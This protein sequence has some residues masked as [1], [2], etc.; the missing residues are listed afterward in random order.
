MAAVLYDPITRKMILLTA[1]VLLDLLLG[2]PHGLWHPVQ[3]IGALAARLERVLRRMFPATC[4][5]QMAAGGC[6]VVCVLCGVAI[7]V[8]GVTVFLYHVHFF[9]GFLAEL[10]WYYSALAARSLHRESR[11]VRLALERDGLSAGRT[12]VSMI[13]GR[14]TKT[15]DE[16]G[17]I[18]AAVETVA[19]NTSD[20]VIAPMLYLA[21]GGCTGGWLYKA[22]NTMDSMVGYKNEAYLYFG[23][24]AAK[25]D[26]AV[27]FIPARLSA[28]F[29]LASCVLFRMHPWRAYTIYRR[30][31]RRHASPNAAHTEA[32]VAGAL[33]VRLAGDASYFGKTVKKA[34]IGDPVR[35]IARED[36]R[37][38]ARLMYGAQAAAYLFCMGMLF[39]E[40][41]CLVI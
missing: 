32:V 6:M 1:A 14:D 4:R 39:L 26:D 2:D 35:P 12:A 40:A 41:S 22:I 5:M 31:R 30:D 13:V 29:L 15:L 18:R 36:I 20:G 33:G 10:Y 34:F 24:A 11:N 25:L 9:A 28:W 23:R 17:V 27:N 21:V 16:A 19:E 8:T 37:L 7:V 3:G 38:A